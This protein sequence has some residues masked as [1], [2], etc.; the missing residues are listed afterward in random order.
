M[1]AILLTV[2]VGFLLVAV[3]VVLFLR[4]RQDAESSSPERD[5]LMPLE[6]ETYRPVRGSRDAP[7]P[8]A[9]SES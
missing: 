2:F 9:T 8:A 7:A 1:N 3:F 6:E 4:Y 5:S